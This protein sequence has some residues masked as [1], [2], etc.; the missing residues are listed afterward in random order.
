MSSWQ[1]RRHRRR[2]RGLA[3]ESTHRHQPDRS[4]DND[5]CGVVTRPMVTMVV[6][7]SHESNS[8]L[9]RS[10][11]DRREAQMMGQVTTRRSSGRGEN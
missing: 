8:D 5:S 11:L 3:Q 9:S 7:S 1:R 4:K 6:D 2:S 10:A